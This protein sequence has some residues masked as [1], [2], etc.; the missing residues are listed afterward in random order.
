MTRP[1]LFCPSPLSRRRGDA[2]RALAAGLL[3]LVASSGPAAADLG[4]FLRRSETADTRVSYAGIKVLRGGGPPR[5]GGPERAPR[6]RTVKVW[7]SAPDQTRIEFLSGGPEG[8]AIIQRGDRHYLRSASGDLRAWPHDSAPARVDLLLE[9]YTVRKLRV[10][11]VAGR[12]AFVLSVEPKHAGNPRKVVWIDSA[13]GLA[14]RTQ[15]FDSNGDLSEESAFQEIDFHPIFAPGLFEV[16]GAPPTPSPPPPAEPDF[17]L[18]RP[19]YVP[20]G[21][22]LVSTATWRERGGRIMAHFRYTDGLNTLSLFERR[23]DSESRRGPGWGGRVSGVAGDMR[24]SLIGDIRLEELQ[25]MAESIK[26]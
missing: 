15:L 8:S 22:L 19:E 13:T 5:R 4:F 7:H 10:E 2:L 18:R 25:K 12:K 23:A 1:R 3:L 14:L 24:F 16:T 6:E 9:N 21:Y 26:R 17:T 11:Q 20:P